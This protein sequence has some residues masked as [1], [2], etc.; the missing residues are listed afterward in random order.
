MKIFVCVMCQ[1][2]YDR[3]AKAFLCCANE[4]K[5]YFFE[6]TCDD[7]CCKNDDGTYACQPTEM[8]REVETT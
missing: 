4:K 1:G 5:K 6:F 3:K 8:Y 7:Q 2:K